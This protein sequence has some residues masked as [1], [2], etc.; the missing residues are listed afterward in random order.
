MSSKQ[1]RYSQSRRAV[2][3]RLSEQGAAPPAK[4][5][6]AK[7]PAAGAATSAGSSLLAQKMA[8]MAR[9]QPA[10]KPRSPDGMTERRAAWA[11]TGIIAL[12]DLQ[13]TA[14]EPSWLEGA[15]CRR[16]VRGSGE[17]KED[18]IGAHRGCL[19]VCNLECLLIRHVQLQLPSVGHRGQLSWWWLP[20]VTTTS[21]RPVKLT[22]IPWLYFGCT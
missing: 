16:W 22:A 12:R 17:H 9:K 15:P 7:A 8:D 14:L 18:L 5:A 13:L 4:A 11:K 21:S 20:G 10:A 3:V 19:F 1:C 6:A 2:T